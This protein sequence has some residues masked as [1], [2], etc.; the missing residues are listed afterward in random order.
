MPPV[1]G[2]RCVYGGTALRGRNDGPK[3]QRPEGRVW[4][5]TFYMDA[6]EVTV[7]AYDAC[8]AAGKCPPE[9]TNYKGFSEPRQPKVGVSW[10]A[11]RDFC[12]AQGKRLP[13]EAEFEKAIRGP[14]G[15]LYAWGNEPPDCERTVFLQRD[16]GRGCGRQSPKPGTG[17]TWPV[18][19]RPAGR[20]GLYDISGNADEWVADWYEHGGYERCGAACRGVNPKGP[21]DGAEKCS[22][23][24]QRIV[25]GGSWYWDESRLPG[26]WRRPHFPC[27]K[28]EYHHFGFRCAKDSRTPFDMVPALFNRVVETLAA[29]RGHTL[30]WQ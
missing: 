22:G 9:K 3:S 5:E 27:N 12:R 19:S 6:T 29:W 17:A 7:E 14:D 1:E 2:M 30:W 4:I 18:A 10:Y 11:A 26:Y 24:T 23:Y 25:R 8:V 15:D 16:T 13:T 20:Y 28:K 21:C